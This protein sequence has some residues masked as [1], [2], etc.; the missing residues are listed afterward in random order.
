M[1]GPDSFTCATEE[2]H[3]VTLREVIP[4][5]EIVVNGILKIPTLFMDIN[6]GN[7]LKIFDACTCLIKG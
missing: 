1:H 6:L 2:P 7:L 5:Y 4:I 3:H